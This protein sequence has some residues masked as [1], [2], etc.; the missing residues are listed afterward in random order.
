[1]T[2]KQTIDLPSMLSFDRKLETSDALMFSGNWENIKVDTIKKNHPKD[3][4]STYTKEVAAWNKIAIVKR[5][6]RS[7][8]S[9]H[10]TSDE[11]K[12]KPNPA[13][14]DADDA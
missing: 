7:T 9:A 6:N 1:M 3:D 13:S 4:G 11:E 10:G 12:K 5:Y 8:Q 2:E 14:S